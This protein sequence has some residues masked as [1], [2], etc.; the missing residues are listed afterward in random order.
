[1]EHALGGRTKNEILIDVKGLFFYLKYTLISQL[2]DSLFVAVYV[3]V[4][5]NGTRFVAGLG[6]RRFLY[7]IAAASLR[8][9]ALFVVMTIMGTK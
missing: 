6:I 3:S 4:R 5:E 9:Y 8:F 1:M 2:L 7:P